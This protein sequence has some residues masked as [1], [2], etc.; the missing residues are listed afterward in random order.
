MLLP[1]F[2][3]M[4]MILSIRTE[5]YLQFFF[6]SGFSKAFNRGNNEFTLKK[7]L[8]YGFRGKGVEWVCSFLTIRS[9]L[10]ET[11]QQRSSSLDV[12]I[13]VTQVSSLIPLLFILYNNDS[14]KSPTMLKSIYLS[15]NT[16]LYL[17]TNPSTDHVSRMSL[18]SV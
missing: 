2:K 5:F 11:K 16:T 3:I 12:N 1:N 4:L 17:D 18:L 8:Y 7:L 13:G 10:I 9:R 15:D 14:I 6:S